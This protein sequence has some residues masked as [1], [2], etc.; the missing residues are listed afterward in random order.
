MPAGRLR[1][2][3]SVAVGGPAM[4]IYLLLER[5]DSLLE[6]LYRRLPDPAPTLLFDKTE[7]AAYRDKSP[8]LLDASV[9]HP[10]L[11]I[12]IEHPDARPGLIISA[13]P[14]EVV[15]AHL[16]HIL[17]VRFEGYAEAFCVIRTR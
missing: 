11:N 9:Q 3:K 15:L 16:R 4:N 14:V 10:L 12:V 6:Q 17:F 1:L 5:T 7:L 13:S 8:V 2:P